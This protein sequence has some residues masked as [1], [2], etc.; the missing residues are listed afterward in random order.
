[1]KELIHD[2]GVGELV[3]EARR[4]SHQNIHNRPRESVDAHCNFGMTGSISLVVTQR[5]HLVGD[6]PPGKPT[7]DESLIGRDPVGCASRGA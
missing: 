4:D 6:R 3:V 1:M 7:T 5:P 2:E